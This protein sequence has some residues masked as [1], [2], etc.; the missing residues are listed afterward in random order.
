MDAKK[1]VTVNRKLSDNKLIDDSAAS[2]AAQLTS[3]LRH[4]GSCTKYPLYLGPQVLCSQ[5]ET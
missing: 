1:R 4:S 3:L 2:D 5:P